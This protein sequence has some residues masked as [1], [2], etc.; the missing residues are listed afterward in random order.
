MMAMDIHSEMQSAEL[1]IRDALGLPPGLALSELMAAYT[2]R[3]H[4][5]RDVFV[6]ALIGHLVSKRVAFATRESAS[7]SV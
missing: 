7:P 6:A 5:D 3:T 4:T 1:K 2:A